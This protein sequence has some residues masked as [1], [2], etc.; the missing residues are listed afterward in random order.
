LSLKS[1]YVYKNKTEIPY[2]EFR[3]QLYHDEATFLDD[4]DLQDTQFYGKPLLDNH[5]PDKVAGMIINAWQSSKDKNHILVLAKV[6]DPEV[7]ELVD[8]GEYSGL[9]VGLTL[10]LEGSDDSAYS[11]FGKQIDEISLC[12]KGFFEPCRV[13]VR[14]SDEFK[15]DKCVLVGLK[16]VKQKFNLILVKCLIVI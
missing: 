2:E 14:A 16:K 1:N 4:A 12:R 10:G 8:S 9:S 6:E 5:N 7:I 13:Y 11:V 3:Q 15:S